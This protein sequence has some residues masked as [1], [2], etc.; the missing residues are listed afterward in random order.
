ME[1]DLLRLG[2]PSTF[3][4]SEE[5]WLEW[6]FQAR[7]FLSLL[8]DTVADDLGRVEGTQEKVETNDL[9]EERRGFARKVYYVLT[10]LLKGP[11]LA[12]LRQVE[13]S[14]G[15]EAWRQLTKRYDSN[16]AGRQHNLLSTIL[17][18]KQSPTEA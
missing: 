4:G 7:A 13:D 16:L 2:R 10:M 1:G 6:A 17:R 9:N 11:P 5:A 12:V 18:P 15:Y 14:N 8:G 3:E